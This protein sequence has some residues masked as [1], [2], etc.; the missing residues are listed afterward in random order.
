MSLIVFYFQQS[1]SVLSF[2]IDVVLTLSID[3]KAVI[4]DES[5]EIV[6]KIED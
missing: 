4:E 2:H 3:T 6:K 5:M 1:T